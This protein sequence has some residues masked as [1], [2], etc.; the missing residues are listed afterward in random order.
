M[1]ADTKRLM[2]LDIFRGITIALMILVNNPGALKYTYIPLKH[3]L[4]IGFP[5]AE[6]V[7]PFFLVIMGV[8][9]YISL[10][11]FN[12]EPSKA[13]IFKILKRTV[14]LFLLGLLLNWLDLIFD[15]LGSPEV[16]N[17]KGVFGILTN[18]DLFQH[19]RFMGVFQRLALAYGFTS[20]LIIAFKTKHLSIVAYSILIVYA[21]ILFLGNGFECSEQNIVS[22]VDQHLLGK[23]HLYALR[24]L[25]GPRIAFNPEA[26]L[27][28][29]PCISQVLIGFLFGKIIF[30]AQ[31]INLRLRKLFAYASI[32]LVTGYLFSFMIPIIK[33]VWTPTYVLVTS[34]SAGLMMALLIILVDINGKQNKLFLMFGVFGINP[35]AL[36]LFSDLL[37]FPVKSLKIMVNGSY[38]TI[39]DYFYNEM[40]T[41]LFG[42]QFGSLL[43]SLSTLLICWL[44]GYILY[45]RHIYIKV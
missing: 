29:L 8:S 35:L 31:D 34:G 39:R 24:S 25:E 12:F 5:A 37:A 14:I 15:A 32:L 10:R 19:F 9:T 27:S 23:D 30:S 13:L 44:L 6:L 28:T 43:Y 38:F 7:F 17:E 26:I 21:V 41:P 16:L 40:L 42:A 36:Y 1:M 22:I 11:K 45:K 18:F 20:L 33:N 3:A 2:S 4:W